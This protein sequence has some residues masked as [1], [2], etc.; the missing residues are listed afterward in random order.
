MIKAQELRIGNYVQYEELKNPSKVWIIDCTETST[1]TKAKPIPLTEEWHNKF[2]IQKNG[3]MQ[4]EYK[5]S[6]RQ[7]IVFSDEY[8]FLL[9]IESM[10]HKKSHRDNICT[11]WNTDIKK[12]NMYVH[13][14]QNLYF[15]LTGEE[16]TIKEVNNEQI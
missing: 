13:E 1:S 8:V 7:I 3:F 4:F 10:D 15:A 11:L 16:L 5:V 14:W 12:R 2:G 9:D 6:K